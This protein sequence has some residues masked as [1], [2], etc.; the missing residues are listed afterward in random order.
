[1]LD[2]IGNTPLVRL[3][4]VVPPRSAEVWI[5]LEGC[6]PTG[7]YKDRMAR[8]LIEGAEARGDLRPGMTVVE[9]TGG[10]TGSS[11]AFVCAVKGYRFRAVSSDAFAPEKLRTMRAFGAEVTIVPSEAGK[12][13]PDLIPRMME[14]TRAFG[15]D[16]DTYL[17][18]QISNRDA[19][20]GYEGLGEEIVEQLGGA[21][22]AFCAGVG[23]A[24]LVMGVTRAFRRLSHRVRIVALEPA[25]S[26]VLSAGRAGTHHVEG[27]GVGFVPPLFDSAQCDEVRAIDETAARSMA[28]RLAAEEG[29]FAGISSG[30]NVVG[31]L[32]LARELGSGHRVVTIACDSGLKYLAGDLYQD[33][34]RDLDPSYAGR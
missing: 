33:Q 9:Y 23:T 10:S 21:P 12:I 7:S 1:V 34:A 26:P 31:A 24:G 8:A 16:P 3:Y 13:T 17:T 22:A 2:A 5:K 6:N 29:V 30:L 20:D 32:Q 27:I 28:R 18:D 25:S 11:L 19:L 15:K 4:K 14:R